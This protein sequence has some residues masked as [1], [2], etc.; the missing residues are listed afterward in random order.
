MPLFSVAV[1]GRRD[2]S[3]TW[4]CRQEHCCLLWTTT[5]L[6]LVSIPAFQKLEELVWFFNKI[7]EL[8]PVIPYYPIRLQC[9]AFDFCLAGLLANPFCMHMYCTGVPRGEQRYVYPATC[10]AKTNQS[11][12]HQMRCHYSHLLASPSAKWGCKKRQV[13]G[14]SC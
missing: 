9:T 4:Q 1:C 3:L 11:F 8:S 10:L 14:P 13:S 6:S 5:V 2:Q 7:A 12:Y